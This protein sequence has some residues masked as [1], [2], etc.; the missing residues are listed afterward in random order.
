MQKP[1]ATISGKM[2]PEYRKW[3][4]LNNET[5]VTQAHRKYRSKLDYPAKAK[6]LRLAYKER[7]RQSFGCLP[8][9]VLN[10][11]TRNNATNHCERWGVREDEFLINSGFGAKKLAE[12]LK[13]TL[14]SVKTRK[15][16]LSVARLV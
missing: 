11:N 3:W 1:K 12:L 7:I 8:E 5:K 2:N 6:K 14:F 9:A 16:R 10:Q 4:S 13:R 15:H